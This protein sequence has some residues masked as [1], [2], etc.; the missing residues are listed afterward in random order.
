MNNGD[1]DEKGLNKNSSQKSLSN[2]INASSPLKK[3]RT[4][5][6]SIGGFISHSG[7]L[8]QTNLKKFVDAQN[9]SMLNESYNSG[10]STTT[11][12]GALGNKIGLAV[13]RIIG[14]TSALTA[15]DEDEIAE[16]IQLIQEL[17]THQD[18]TIRLTNQTKLCR[19]L[20]NKDTKKDKN[21]INTDL[22]KNSLGGGF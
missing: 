21:K 17:N 20:D 14:N 5:R 22:S 4:S 19:I 10:R 6:G 18:L 9:K 11:A 15:N 8:S 13:S 7:S 2:Y 3:M 1:A 12:G 16:L